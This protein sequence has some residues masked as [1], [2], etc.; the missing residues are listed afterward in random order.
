MI[1]IVLYRPE[2]P[3]NAGNVIR[4]SVN[5]GARLHFI[6]PL[7]F[8][9][10]D[11]RMLRAG[12]DYH[13]LANLTVHV[14][15]EEFLKKEQPSRLIASTSRGLIAPTDFHFK[16]GD[17]V[18]FGR[19]KEGLSDEVYA[20]VPEDLRLRIP[21]IPESRCLNLSNSVAVV[22]Y[23]AWRQLGFVGAALHRPENT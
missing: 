10:D 13:E 1:N 6:G 5:C 3:S 12:L 4:L 20:Q 18:I 14:N 19:E 7:G 21:M 8:F 2:M 15:F 9:L 23:E 17:Y 11:K 22:A 16:D